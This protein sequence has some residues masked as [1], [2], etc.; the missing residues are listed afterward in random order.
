M[1][2]IKRT[3]KRK[4]AVIIG[5]NYVKTPNS[6][7]NGCINDAYN[8]EQFLTTQCGYDLNNI[9]KLVDVGTSDKY[10]T[11]KNIIA[12]FDMLVSKAITEPDTELWI[13]YSGHGSNMKDLD[14]DETDGFDECIC[15]SDYETAGI[16]L[17]DFIYNNLISKLPESTT[18]FALFDCCHSGTVLDLPYIYI[19][20]AVQPNN[21]KL[22]SAASVVCISGCL[23]NQTSADAFINQNYAGAMTWAF[24]KILKG[25]KYNISCVNLVEKMKKILKTDGYAQI[26]ALTLNKTDDYNKLFI[27]M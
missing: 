26:P 1:S 14:G 10:P 5:I 18:L 7:L 4:Y 22:N 11:K 17:D 19:N 27:E 3:N 9:V 8:I 23:D 25:A 24:L 16:I 20:N 21:K 15:P 12:S 13:S 6:S 2:I